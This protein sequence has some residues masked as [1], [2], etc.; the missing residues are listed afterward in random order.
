MPFTGK[1][2]LLLNNLFVINLILLLMYILT[3]Y[4]DQP[5]M[6]DAKFI[7]LLWVIIVYHVI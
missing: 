4:S 5:T 2:F 6:I 7:W 1:V 3:V